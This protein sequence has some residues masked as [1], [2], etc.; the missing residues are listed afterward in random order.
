MSNDEPYQISISNGPFVDTVYLKKP[1][2]GE[3]G[4]G[5]QSE[6]TRSAATCKSAATRSEATRSEA[7][8][9]AARNP[10][11]KNAIA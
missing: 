10:E 4:G 7:T 6:A 5:G 2:S 3:N 11:N 9:S 8:R 1:K